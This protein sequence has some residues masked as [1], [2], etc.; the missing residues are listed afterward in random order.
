MIEGNKI[1]YTK[2]EVKFDQLERER[3]SVCV[4]V[5]NV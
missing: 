3:D 4:C 1:Y 2:I 5:C